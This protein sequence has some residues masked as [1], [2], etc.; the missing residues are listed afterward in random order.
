MGKGM[1]GVLKRKDGT[2]FD[3]LDCD[4]I[5]TIKKWAMGRGGSY[6]LIVGWED[7]EGESFD[8]YQ[9]DEDKIY[10]MTA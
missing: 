10:K 6:A 7:L 4:D 8:Y 3:L 2:Q 5:E 1:Y 9:I